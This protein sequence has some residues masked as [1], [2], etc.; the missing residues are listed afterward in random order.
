MSSK[1]ISLAKKVLLD[2]KTLTQEALQH[3]PTSR[4]AT[5]QLLQ[6]QVSNDNQVAESLLKLDK[7]LVLLEYHGASEYMKQKFSKEEQVIQVNKNEASDEKGTVGKVAF[8]ITKQQKLVLKQ[9]LNYSDQDI[10]GMK[11]VEAML[12]MEHKVVKSNMEGG[13][14]DSWKETLQNLVREN[15]MLLEK[16]A[17]DAQKRIEETVAKSRDQQEKVESATSSDLQLGFEQPISSEKEV[18]NALS[19]VSE[20]SENVSKSQENALLSSS[21]SDD[22]A[23]ESD[24]WYEVVEISICNENKETTSVVGLYRSKKE[25]NELVEIKTDLLNKRKRDEES[26]RRMTKQDFETQGYRVQRRHDGN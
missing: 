21:E 22:S 23:S 17:Q 1:Y 4:I 5:R 14:N 6:K 13:D 10:K 8:M 18:S 25:A 9:S 11:P 2:S 26:K 16:E 15:E 12:L 24:I 7:E 3:K 20:P 19:I